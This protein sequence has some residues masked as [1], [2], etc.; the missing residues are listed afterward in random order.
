MNGA[1]VNDLD[2]SEIN[3]LMQQAEQ[4]EYLSAAVQKNMNCA[5]A[6]MWTLLAQ[7]DERQKQMLTALEAK[8]TGQREQIDQ[9]ID[10]LDNL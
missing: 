6:R 5:A 9:I 1:T 10:R 3:R 2:Y 7:I 4:L 8:A